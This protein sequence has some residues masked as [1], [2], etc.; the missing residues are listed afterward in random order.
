MLRI[1]FSEN[2]SSRDNVEAYGRAR[3]A[4]DDNIIRVRKVVRIIRH[5]SVFNRYFCLE[6]GRNDET[7][8]PQC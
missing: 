7:R 2:R 8:A 5:S 4:T 1:F 3:Q 6:H